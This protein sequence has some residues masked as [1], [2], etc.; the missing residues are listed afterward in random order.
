MLVIGLTG[1][2]GSG[3]STVAKLFAERGIPIIDADVIAR[4]FTKPDQPAFFAIIDHFSQEILLKDGTL[5]R[6]KLAKIVFAHPNERAWLESLLHPLIR[7]EIER[8]IK[9][10]TSPYCIAVIPLLTDLKPYPFIQRVLVVDAALN[11]QIT[12]VS[13][14]DN[15]ERSHIEAIIGTQTKRNHRLKIADDIITNDGVLADLVP[16]VERLHQIYLGMAEKSL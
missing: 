10:K 13:A 6:A 3:K 14:R 16:Q 15:T 5:N 1:G 11:N 7:Q 12:R 8:Q 9:N 4:E 2:I